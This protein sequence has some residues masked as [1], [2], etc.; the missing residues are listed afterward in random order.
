MNGSN[1][2]RGQRQRH[3]S[4]DDRIEIQKTKQ[5]KKS[6]NTQAER[7][8]H[9]KHINARQR[10]H[11]QHTTHKHTRHNQDDSCRRWRRYELARSSLY[12]IRHVFLILVY[13]FWDACLLPL[14][15]N[16]DDYV[17]MTKTDTPKNGMNIRTVRWCAYFEVTC[18]TQ[19]LLFCSSL[20]VLILIG[21][22]T[23]HFWAPTHH[24]L[25]LQLMYIMACTCPC[26]RRT[27]TREWCII[28]QGECWRR[29]V[30]RY[31]KSWGT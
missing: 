22:F 14:N 9:N 15:G 4:T 5:F 11:T 29:E 16:C 24:V 6:P 2:N 13:A 28:K 23:L 18:T 12:L 7:K 20:L 10:A 8:T 19:K 27:N 26:F 1:T 30:Q 21:S 31:Q 3:L 17:Y 25:W